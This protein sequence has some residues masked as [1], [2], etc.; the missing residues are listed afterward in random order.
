MTAIS[1]TKATRARAHLTIAQVALA[2]WPLLL[3]IATLVAGIFAVTQRPLRY[4][5]NIGYEEG[6]GS[7]LPF[8]QGWNTA[9]P[10][11]APPDARSYRW[12]GAES[13]IWLP[14]VAGHT[15]IATVEQ[16]PASANPAA[17]RGALHL[18]SAGMAVSHALN[19]ERTL[20]ILLP[21]AATAAGRLTFHAPTFTPPGDPRVLG[22]PI[23]TA[24][25][26][27]LD[28][29]S[30]VPPLAL[31]WPTLLLPIAWGALRVIRVS[32]AIAL[33][34]G[35]S[36][37][38]LL[39][40]ALWGDP[41]RFAAAGRPLLIGAGW[42]MI[43]GAVTHGLITRLHQRLRLRVSPA[44]AG[45]VA[46]IVGTLMALRYGG[47]LY[48][49]SMGGDLGFHVNRLN[50][51]IGGLIHLTSRHRGIDFPYPSAVY[52]LLAP[53]RLLPISPFALLEWADALLGALG[54]I[55]IAYLG[56][57]GL[58]SERGALLAATTYALLAPAMMALWWSFLA[59]IF[60]QEMVAVLIA[61]LA[62]G[63]ERLSGRWGIALVFATLC[64]IF[65]GHFGLWINVSLLVAG[66]LLILWWRYRD[67]AWR[68]SIAGLALAFVL[69]E[70]A[71]I[72]LFYS[73]YDELIRQKIAEF[74]TGGMSAV[75]GGRAPI[76]RGALLRSLWQDGLVAHYAVIGVPLALLGGAWLWHEQRDSII[77]WLFWGTVVIAVIQGAIPFITSS[78]ITTRW[79]SF[80]AWAIAIGVAVVLERLWS[81]GRIGQGIALAVL[82]WIGSNT[83]WLWIS[84]LGYRIRPPEPF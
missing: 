5:I 37:I 23:A 9:E 40:A 70:I 41:L 83:L 54:V 26:E 56:L 62:L 29:V 59:H 57:R 20:H 32:R 16:L 52:I 46:L 64:M 36:L 15:L 42:G 51:V 8:L 67:T 75:Q 73:A 21:P 61:L 43:I 10:Y 44:F 25:L 12:S 76:T 30:R 53:L 84:A 80:C 19:V 45:G 18:S 63:W 14:G 31:F 48:P 17:E 6:W 68:G 2:Q 71:A 72:G 11:Y 50:E 13:W 60:A 74:L 4:T 24:G 34:V 22:A 49:D 28:G 27:S 66:G 47:R 39:L 55:P 38:A 77:V 1:S 35:L 82:L 33:L 78:T 58:R 3:L 81:R 69:A 7:D 79:L 65:F